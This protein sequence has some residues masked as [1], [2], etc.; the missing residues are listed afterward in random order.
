M[1]IVNRVFFDDCFTVLEP[2]GRPL[3]GAIPRQWEQV[4]VCVFLFALQPSARALT[5]AWANRSRDSPGVGFRS[6]PHESHE[7]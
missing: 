5:S 1:V 2:C 7:M 3:R 6:S 4:W